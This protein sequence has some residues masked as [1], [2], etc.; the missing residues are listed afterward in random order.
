MNYTCLIKLWCTI[1]KTFNHLPGIR[2]NLALLP[3]IIQGFALYIDFEA[4]YLHYFWTNVNHLPSKGKVLDSFFII[5]K[6]KLILNIFQVIAL[7]PLRSKLRINV[8][9][10]RLA[11]IIIANILINYL[12]IIHRHAFSR[13]KCLSPS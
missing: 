10:I 3:I 2:Y 12:I 4:L 13:K 6:Q 11:Q 7:R 8:L 1:S 5:Y 9:N